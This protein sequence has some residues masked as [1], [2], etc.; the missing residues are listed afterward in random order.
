MKN[1]C[2]HLGRSGVQFQYRIDLFYQY[3]NRESNHDNATS[4]EW[5]LEAPTCLQMG[6][7][8]EASDRREEALTPSY[9]GRLSVFGLWGQKAFMSAPVSSVQFWRVDSSPP[10]GASIRHESP[11]LWAK[12]VLKEPNFSLGAHLW[13]TRFADCVVECFIVT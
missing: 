9:R 4:G 10:N 8:L 1:W 13:T 12:G 2:S 6:R 3:P 5:S 7:I 11:H